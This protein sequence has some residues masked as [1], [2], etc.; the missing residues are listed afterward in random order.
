[1]GGTLSGHVDIHAGV[2]HN[3]MTTGLSILFKSDWIVKPHH[4]AHCNP[5]A[6]NKTVSMF[7]IENSKHVMSDIVGKKCAYR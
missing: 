1:L 5:D 4:P 3:I 7:K 2:L 6:G